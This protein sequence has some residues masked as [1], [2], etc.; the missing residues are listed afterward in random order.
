MNAQSALPVVGLL[1]FAQLGGMLLAHLLTGLDLVSGIRWL[2]PIGTRPR[3]R[4]SL[5]QF[6]VAWLFMIFLQSAVYFSM[7]FVPALQAKE[8]SSIR[9]MIAVSV[10]NIIFLVAAVLLVGPGWKAGLKRLGLSGPNIGRQISIGIRGAF[11]ISPWVYLVNVVANLIFYA[12]P[13]EVMKMLDN[14]LDQSTAILAGV[15]AVILAPLAEEVLFRGMLL[16]TLIRMS[17]K[18]PATDRQIP[19]QFANIA[20]SLFFAVLHANAWPAP[21]GIFVFSLGLGK[22]YI[23]TGRLLPCVIAHALF[24]Y[25]GVLGMLFAVLAKKAGMIPE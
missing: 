6:F 19:V 7:K 10:S 22:L 16:G 25:T 21:I 17:R 1:L 3:V 11:L 14:H 12:N 15:S 5:L 2:V 8:Q 23:A 20:T 24:N 18:V 4:W 13:H 9:A